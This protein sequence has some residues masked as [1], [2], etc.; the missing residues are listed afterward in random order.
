MART[1]RRQVSLGSPRDAQSTRFLQPFP[2][3][4][5]ISKPIPPPYSEVKT[6]RREVKRCWGGEDGWMRQWPEMGEWMGWDMREGKRTGKG[7]TA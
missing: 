4:Y 5:R 1:Q 7:V 6:W 3:K 2:L